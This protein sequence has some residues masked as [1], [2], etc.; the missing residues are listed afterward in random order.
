MSELLDDT[1]FG[2]W[3]LFFSFCVH[4]HVYHQGPGTTTPPAHSRGWLLELG[5]AFMFLGNKVTECAS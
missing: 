1:S 4:H 2:Q 3:D 5:L